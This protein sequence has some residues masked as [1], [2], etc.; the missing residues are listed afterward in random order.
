[1]H[2]LEMAGGKANAFFV[3]EPAWHRLGTVLND[4]PTTEEAIRLMNADWEVKK[5]ELRTVDGE[6]NDVV[7][8]GFKA[9]VRET[10]N[11]VFD[12]VSDK[13]Q[14]VQNK[15]AFSFFNNVIAAR[16]AKLETGAM[17]HGGRQLFLTARMGES[18]DVAKGD[19]IS[20]FI[21]LSLGHDRSRSV[22]WMFTPVRVVCANTL[23]L[24]H[25]SERQFEGT[26][27]HV[28]DVSAKLKIAS[29]MMTQVAAASMMA[30][31]IF[32]KMAAKPITQIGAIKFFEEI[33]PDPEDS[34]SDAAQKKRTLCFEL[35]ETGLGADIP[36]VRG[37]VWGAYNAVT[38]A[39]DHRL[40]RSAAAVADDL[41]ASAF[42][43]GKVQETRANSVLFGDGSLIKKRAMSTAMAMAIA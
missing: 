24:A 28:G 22:R 40:G 8:K 36:G 12:V 39:V 9:L 23:S 14:P 16:Y 19:E 3:K 29:G 27:R 33:F 21:L 31:D 30:K 41:I 15:E 18:F 6:G 26:I 7:V 35:F 37:T 42:K 20:Q 13:Y 5:R 25:T 1:M 17:L 2:A 4:P 34:D 10:D 43:T 11:K 32:R 38:E